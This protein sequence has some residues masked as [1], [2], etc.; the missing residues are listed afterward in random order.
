MAIPGAPRQPRK[1]AFVFIFITVLLDMLAFGVVAPVLPKLVES[2]LGGQTARAAEMLALFGSAWA[3]M[4]FLG[5]PVL[6]SLSDRF[7]RRPVVLASNFGQAADFVLMALAPNLAWLFVGRLISGITSASYST[8]G[9]YI[10]DV[11]PAD[12]RAERFGLLGAAFGIGFILGPALGGILGAY[13]LRAPF[14]AAA[15]LCLANGLY[16]LFVLPESLPVEQ[17][18]RFQWKVANPVG[19]LVFLRSHPLLLKLAIVVFLGG[20]AH[21]ALPSTYVIYAGYRFGWD[22]RTVGLTLAL[23]GCASLIVQALLV[24][25]A[26]RRLGERGAMLGGLAFGSAGFLVYG[27]AGTGAVFLSG[28]ALTALWGLAGPATQGQMSRLAGASEQGQLQGAIASLMGLAEIIGPGLF[29]LT[30]AMALRAPGPFQ[31]PGAPFLLAG[32]LLGLSALMAVRVLPPAAAAPATAAAPAERAGG[33]ATS[34][35]GP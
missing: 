9:A 1:A 13:D 31:A 26:I 18:K 22:E 27:L 10:A 11:T 25:P 35:E 20:I 32:V 4:Q 30:F 19:S 29:P 34:P 28:I 15:V 3:V 21:A 6:G 33:D 14:W 2:F 7:G 16:G 24:G 23:V 8:A 17:R 5:S 12:K